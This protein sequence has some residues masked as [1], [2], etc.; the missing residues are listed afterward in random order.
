MVRLAIGRSALYNYPMADDELQDNAV[1][2]N[3][4]KAMP[5]FPLDSVTL[6]PQQVLPLHIFEPRYREM[7]ARA[8]D[9]AGQIAMAVFEGDRWKQEYHGRPPVR[10]AVCVGHICHHETTEDGRYNL[11]L[12]GVCRARIIRE[13]PPA[14]DRLYREALLAPV[15]VEDIEPAQLEDIRAFLDRAL[16]NGPLTHMKAAAP[17]LEYIHQDEVPTSALLELVSFTMLSDQ[18]LRYRLL[19]EGDVQVRARL[20]EGELDRLGD[21]I[22]RASAQRPEDWPKGCSW[23]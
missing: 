3:F 21:L 12:Q 18:K 8:L 2:V 22:R 10:P 7:A 15:G 16:S 9:G 4:G 6:L 5:L 17:I 14:D 20:I 13:L 19:A 23:N 1:Q 11:W